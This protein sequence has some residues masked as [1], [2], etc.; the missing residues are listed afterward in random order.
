MF[1]GLP[2]KKRLICTAMLITGVMLCFAMLILTVNE[3]F[4]SRAEMVRTM[5]ALSKV[6]SAQSS[7]SVAFKDKTDATATLNT[8]SNVPVVIYAALYMKDGELLA[9]YARDAGHID[10]KPSEMGNAYDFDMKSLSITN[11]VTLD[12]EKIG[13]FYIKVSLWPMYYRIIW[14]I[15]IALLILIVSIS[16][17]YVLSAKLEEA[18]ANPI[19]D[20]THLMETVS[21]N[22]NYSL[23]AS[24]SNIYEL[25][26]MAGGFNE[27]LSQ[28][29]KRDEELKNH[30]LHLEDEVRRRTEEL[31]K[32][33]IR[34]QQELIE[35]EKAEVE[36]KRLQ[37]Q[38]LQAQKME[39]V[40]KLAGGIAHD[41]NN[42]LT[43]IIGYGSLLKMHV[44]DDEKM[45]QYVEQVLS[46][47]E[48]AAKLVQQLLAFSRKQII[49][50]KPVS[51]NKLLKDVTKLMSRLLPENIELSVMLPDMEL[52]AVIDG[53]QIEQAI[54]NMATNARDAMPNGGM[55]GIYA[56]AVT[57]DDEFKKAYG[58]GKPGNYAL[59]IVYDT[60]EGMDENTRKM[61]F[62]PFFTTKE[63]GKGTGL[64]LAMVYGIIKQHN[65]YINVY[66]EPGRGTTFK[67]YLPLVKSAAIEEHKPLISRPERGEETILVAEDRAD[68]RDL[69]K[70]I[71]ENFGY[72]V[73]TAVDG[74]DAVNKFNEHKADIDM[75]IFD[76]VMPKKSGKEAYDEI[77][78]TN[79][80]MRCLFMSGYTADI[81]N[82]KA[83][84]EDAIEFI[85]KPLSPH[86]I[87][88][89]VREILDKRE[90]K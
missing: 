65:G 35:R 15:V 47:S 43:A 29:E 61:I 67:I 39:A 57:I 31:G 77:I 6:I 32:T 89:K 7:A 27:M 12:N 17:T 10:Y 2:I 55:L 84:L 81:I 16:G 82:K 42:M 78:R 13:I 11:P 85:S 38:L 30:R 70:T 90:Q 53:V 66:S 83:M 79:P 20:L 48:K 33:N 50:P 34:L 58:Y 51:I 5:T 73:I 63:V 22:K 1:H 28:I 18:I 60:G 25:N 36:Q 74:D 72:T 19:I 23:R 75:L 9:H 80:D 88:K 44:E 62:D 68:V 54:I 86:D 46:S 26:L 4:T 64:G 41:F 69:I 71:L 52:T 21:K 37:M 56:D 87:L 24:E 40:G 3:F 49:N 59:I 76:V 14:H 45:L 8:L